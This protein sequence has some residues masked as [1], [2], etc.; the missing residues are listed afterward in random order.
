MSRPYL[1][2]VIPAYNEANRLPLTLI[3]IDRHLSQQDFPSEIIVVVSQGTDNTPEILK[4]FQGIIKNLR[5]I[6]L[7]DN[8]GRG[9]ALKTG[10]LAAHGQWRLMMDA[11]NSTTI[12]ECAKMLPVVT[13]ENNKCEIAIGSRY[14]AGAQMDPPAPGGKTFAQRVGHFFINV[15]FVRRVKDT[16]CGFKLFSAM[17]AEK[18]FKRCRANGW[19]IDTEA[20]AV[21]QRLG[22]AI[23]EV[24]VFWAYD[25]ATHRTSRSFFSNLG[26]HLSLL[27]NVITRKYSA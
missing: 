15:F 18:I 6:N 4:R 2:V 5:V 1:S 20:L 12:L 17:A 8:L 25:P 24:P 21:A 11:D 3:D 10:M 14:I 19:A 22:Y 23:K 26:E 7:S 16:S 13:D 9:H 27:G